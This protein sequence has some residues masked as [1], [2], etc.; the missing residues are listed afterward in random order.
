[1][2]GEVTSQVFFFFF[3]KV[4]RVGKRRWGLYETA[5]TRAGARTLCPLQVDAATREEA[6]RSIAMLL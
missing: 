2:A 1:M 4:A 5:S 6:E 3:L